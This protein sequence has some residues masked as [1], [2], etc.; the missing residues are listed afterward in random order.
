MV[1]MQVH[2]DYE[3]PVTPPYLIP[4]GP[5]IDGAII[6]TLNGDWIGCRIEEVDV[7]LTDSKWKLTYYYADGTKLKEKDYIPLEAE[8]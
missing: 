4:M 3:H 1:Y 5:V 6:L 7:K 8:E 2:E